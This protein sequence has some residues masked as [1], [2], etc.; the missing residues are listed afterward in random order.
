MANKNDAPLKTSTA[1][2]KKTEK[3]LSFGKRIVRWFRDMRSELKKVVWPTGKLITDNT[4]VSL[5]VMAVSAVVI[6]GFDKVA[7]LGI[8]T[9]I[10]LVG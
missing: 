10:R 5:V 1:A 3:K 8:S 4:T 6:W 7:A 9:L 2:V